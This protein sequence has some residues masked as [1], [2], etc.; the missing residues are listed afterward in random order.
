MRFAVL[1]FY[2]NMILTIQNNKIMSKYTKNF[3]SNSI[4]FIFIISLF[5]I[6]PKWNVWK[7]ELSGQAVLKEAEWS[8]KVTIEEAKAKYE[9]AKS[10][11]MA[12]VER[13][14]GVADANK[15]IGD[16][17]KNN[18]EYL[19]YLYIQGLQDKENNIIYVPT[20]AGLPILEA[21]KR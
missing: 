17:L 7:K 5:F 19:R 20:E 16:S 12:E 18:D 9:S 14:K 2:M 8:R 21:G 10:L 4:L 15:I 6:I 3:I 13:A 1:C 11:A